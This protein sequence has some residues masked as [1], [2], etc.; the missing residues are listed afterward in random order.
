MATI[1]I[2]RVEVAKTVSGNSP[3][4]LDLPEAAS[5]TFKK[6]AVLTLDGV[7]HLI[8]A[9]AGEDRVVGV[10]SE[11]AQNNAVAGAAKCGVWIANVDTVFVGNVSGSSVIADSDVGRA[12]NM[13]VVGDI[14]VI[15]KTSAT[16]M[17]IIMSL[18]PRDS[19]GDV[20]G[21]LHFIFH[22]L[23]RAFDGTS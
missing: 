11:D 23:V 13:A 2:R 18:D 6:G 22:G 20:N 1:S 7:G 17:V 5:Q 15:D 9:T 10:A 3:F 8:L 21:R 12:Y 14:F 4:T 19:V 16:R